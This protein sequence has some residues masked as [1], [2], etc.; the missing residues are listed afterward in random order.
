M[1]HRSGPGPLLGAPRG[2][3]TALIVCHFV[4]AACAR[5]LV[6]RLGAGAPSSCSGNLLAFPGFTGSVGIARFIAVRDRSP[7]RG[8]NGDGSDSNDG[9][10]R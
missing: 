6:R 7:R 5:P 2:R 9:A 8:A 4:L 1:M 10:S 3:L